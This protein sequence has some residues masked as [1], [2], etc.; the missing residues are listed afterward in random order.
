MGDKYIY[1]LVV[2]PKIPIFYESDWIV[3]DINIHIVC[4]GKSSEN[5]LQGLKIKTYTKSFTVVPFLIAK[6]WK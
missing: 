1:I 3:L 6:H 2:T 5:I 4:T